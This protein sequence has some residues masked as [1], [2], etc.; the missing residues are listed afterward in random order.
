MLTI[1]YALP[2]KNPEIVFRQGAVKDYS[3][4][5]KILVLTAVRA[6][7]CKHESEHP[8]ENADIVT[9][10]TILLG[11]GDWLEQRDTLRELWMDH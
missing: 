7:C 4:I 3:D 9:S 2:L 1:S 10:N 6:D 8:L 11:K 5:C